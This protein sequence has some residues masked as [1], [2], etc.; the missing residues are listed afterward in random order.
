MLTES[1]GPQKPGPPVCVALDAWTPAVDPA[2][3]QPCQCHPK[4]PETAVSL[5]SE[6]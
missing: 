3:H 5:V 4:T 1:R 6:D 2:P